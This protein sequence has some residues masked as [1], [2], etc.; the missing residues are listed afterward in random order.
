MLPQVSTGDWADPASRTIARCLGIAPAFIARTVEDPARARD[1][2][3]DR[4]ATTSWQALQSDLAASGV[5]HTVHT[6]HSVHK[7]YN[8][9]NVNSAGSAS[10][11]HIMHILDVAGTVDSVKSVGSVDSVTSVDSASGSAE[12]CGH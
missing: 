5:Q 1:I 9:P 2:W 7:V 8:I 4:A 3:L 6:V 12:H 10:G 11:L